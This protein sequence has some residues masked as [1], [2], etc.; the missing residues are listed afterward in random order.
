M[1]G[2]FLTKIFGSQ[3]ERVLKKMTPLVDAINQLEAG[4]KTLDDD[5]LRARTGDL[6]TRL[7]NGEPLDDLLPEAFA[8]VREASVRT[9][10]MRHFDCQLIGGMV[11]LSLIHI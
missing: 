5:A 4:L 1:L 7:T 6:K 10:G 11:L 9:L 8:L 3:N 2:Q